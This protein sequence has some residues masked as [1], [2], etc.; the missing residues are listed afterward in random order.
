MDRLLKTYNIWRF[1]WCPNS[2][3]HSLENVDPIENTFENHQELLAPRSILYNE[4]WASKSIRLEICVVS[5]NTFF[6]QCWK[7][8]QY[9][10]KL[11]V[12]K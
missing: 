11:K 4:L 7:P 3:F 6:Y 5:Y 8:I 2:I 1:L 12:Y 10:Q 9:L